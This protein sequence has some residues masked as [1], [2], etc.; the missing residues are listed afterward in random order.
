VAYQW[1]FPKSSVASAPDSSKNLTI[2][3]RRDIIAY[4]ENQSRGKLANICVYSR[5]QCRTHNRGINGSVTSRIDASPFPNSFRACSTSP[6]LQACT[7]GAS[8]G[9]IFRHRNLVPVSKSC[10]DLGDLAMTRKETDTSF[11]PEGAGNC[12]WKAMR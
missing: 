12:I 6:S 10:H 5:I 11:H 9:M 2:S 7:I 8:A 4:Y 3:A 1:Y